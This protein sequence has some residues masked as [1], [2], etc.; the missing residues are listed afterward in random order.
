MFFFNIERVFDCFRM[1]VLNEEDEKDT[2][3][4]ILIYAVTSFVCVM[5][6]IVLVYVAC[7]KRYRL[8]WFEKNL[9]ENA[10]NIKEISNRYVRHSANQENNKAKDK[11]ALEY[12]IR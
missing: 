11:V 2:I 6:L 3:Y 1:D 12:V 9:L 10:D 8:N 7:A 4:A 5:L